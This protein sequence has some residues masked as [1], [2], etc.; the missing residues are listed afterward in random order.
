[1]KQLLNRLP[2]MYKLGLLTLIS[3]IGLLTAS[4]YLVW[5]EY[6][7]SR[8]DR[9]RLV[10]NMVEVA[11]SVLN[12][13]YQFETSG[14]MPR[15]EAQALAKASIAQMR[16]GKNDYFWINDMDVNIVMHPIKPELNG[17]SGSAIRDPKGLAVFVAVVEKVRK[18]KAGFVQYL[19][20]K[21]GLEQPVEKI[22]YVKGFE[23]WG[24]VVGSGLYTDDLWTEFIANAS[25]IGII[26]FVLV[27]I[28]GWIA[29]LISRSVARGIAKAVSVVEAMSE[30][31][32]SVSI[33]ARGSDEIACLLQSMSQMQV[34][35]SAVVT[36]V[37]QGSESVAQASAELA[38]GNIDLSE[39]TESQASALEETAASMEQLSSTVKQNAANAQQA[40]ALAV[41]ASLVAVNGGEVVAQVVDTMRDI[42]NS[43]RKISDIISVIDGIA[44]QTNILALNAA[45]EAARAGEQGRGFAVVASEVRS[46][47]GRSAEAAKEIKSLISDS[48][49][50]V[51]YGTNLV[52]R[53]GHTMSEVVDAIRRVTDL[54]G[55]I[56]NASH[57][58]SEGVAQVGQAVMQMDRV[59]Q[60]NA[61][62]VEE[63]AAA[64]T[65]LK[66][67]AN[68]LV[69]TV[70]VFRIEQNS[71]NAATRHPVTEASVH[72][73]Q[74]A[75]QIRTMSNKVDRKIVRRVAN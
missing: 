22:S 5:N 48:V 39:R 26:I 2:V 51:S 34:G 18:D 55:E 61:A 36:N 72:R 33:T 69:Q 46:L 32:L 8:Q 62:L 24:W 21:P 28:T 13:A 68:E 7:Q 57:E 9:E 73:L 44:F 66:M 52:D 17:K 56:S 15:E 29:Y 75:G 64:A 42:N 25:Q 35:L 19:W 40:N 43:S 20:P 59:T 53:A 70:S 63:M 74:N 54:M 38:Q 10:L 4:S 41:S 3:I 71:S 47:A 50:K 1:M 11:S 37:R 49:E 65:T 23:P 45:V 58:Q 6:Q 60:E 31:D 16:Y 27:L 12:W 14:K 30:G 67:Q